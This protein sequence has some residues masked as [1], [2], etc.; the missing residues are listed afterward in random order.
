MSYI[1]ILEVALVI[2]LTTTIRMTFGFGD[3][4]LA[5]PL[6]ALIVGTKTSAPIVA[7]F[8]IIISIAIIIRSKSPIFIKGFWHLFIFI[9][10]GIPIGIIYLKG[11][12]ETI[13]KI[14]LGAI[15][16]L[17][18]SIKLFNA[19]LL[20][21]KDDK[22]A[23]IFGLTSG[24]L[25]GAYNTNGP[26]IIIYGNMRNWDAD[27]FRLLLQGFFLPTNILIIIGHYLA[28]LWTETALT[29][30]LYSLPSLVIGIIA[31]EVL[32]KIIS[33]EKFTFYLYIL[34][35]FLGFILI[36]SSLYASIK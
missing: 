11:T 2:L 5:M 23:F 32:R 10:L 13:V 29:L 1:V 8:S 25:G 31:G 9:I 30:L 26:P 20:E 34:L 6:L 28:G 4:L 18:A 3:A 7:I 33:S 14:V 24:I 16:V 19:K 15:L 12:D 17:F 22:Y 36:F 35:I 21:L 27:K